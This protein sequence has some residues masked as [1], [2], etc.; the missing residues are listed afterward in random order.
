MITCN[1][2]SPMN[3]TIRCS[4]NIVKFAFK[5]TPKYD[6]E[7]KSYIIDAAE[8]R[9]WSKLEEFKQDGDWAVSDRKVAS[10]WTREGGTV[11]LGWNDMNTFI[12]HRSQIFSSVDDRPPWSIS[13][14]QTERKVIDRR[15]L[16]V[17]HDEYA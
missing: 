16:Q 6:E 17:A 3:N 2:L 10:V 14:C 7:K 1:L 9:P 15:N 12:K 4:R 8:A 5:T 13:G 11:I